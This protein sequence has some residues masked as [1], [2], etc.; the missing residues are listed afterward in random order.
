[1]KAA[2]KPAFTLEKLHTSTCTYTDELQPKRRRHYEKSIATG[3][4]RQGQ[5]SFMERL[6]YVMNKNSSLI[7][8]GNTIQFIAFLC[9]HLSFGR[10][11]IHRTDII[12]DNSIKQHV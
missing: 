6:L 11:L 2:T 5:T 3:E 12:I 4:V 7:Y 1:M 10:Y 8:F 9:K